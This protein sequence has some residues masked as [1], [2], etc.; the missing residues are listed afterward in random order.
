MLDET[1][2]DLVG[3]EQVEADDEAGDEDDGGALDQ[4]L[5]AGPL[6]LLSSAQDSPMN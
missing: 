2:E 5:L 6:D 1:P 4:L 3:E